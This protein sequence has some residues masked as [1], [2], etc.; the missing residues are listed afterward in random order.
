M[1]TKIHIAS[2]TTPNA[3]VKRKLGALNYGLYCTGCSEFF[4]AAVVEQTANAKELE[5]ISDG[6]ICFQCPFCSKVQMRDASEIGA[7]ILTERL[8]KKPKPPSNFH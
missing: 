2:G 3:L 4:A 1:A 8:K 6:P 7:V 5:F